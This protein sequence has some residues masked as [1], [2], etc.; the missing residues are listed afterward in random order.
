MAI[1]QSGSYAKSVVVDGT[2]A[3]VSMDFFEQIAADNAIHNKTPV[4]INI[5]SDSNNKATSN[6][7]MTASLSGS[8]VT[9]NWTSIPSAGALTVDVVLLF[10][11]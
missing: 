2:N 7:G 5:A 3:S 10:N 11:A 4:S 6:G 1:Y 9:I 8:V